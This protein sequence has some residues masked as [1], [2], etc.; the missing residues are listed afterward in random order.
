MSKTIVL[1]Q[2]KYGST[3][4]YAQWLGEAL[5]CE[6]LENKKLQP[7]RLNDYDT[8]LLGGHLHAGGIAG[9]SFLQKNYEQL[10]HKHIRVFGV[11]ASPSDPEMIEQCR[12]RMRLPDVPFF[13]FRGAWQQDKMTWI[14]RKLCSM[15]KKAL[16]KKDSSTFA[17]WEKALVESIDGN[18]DWT[19]KRFL[20]PLL[21]SL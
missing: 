16:Q 17:P 12:Q 15:L 14:D 7:G 21:E 20:E 19:D 13:Y 18:F 2:S 3:A 9:I 11:G 8:I 1:Y 10:K 6:V 5:G 4:R